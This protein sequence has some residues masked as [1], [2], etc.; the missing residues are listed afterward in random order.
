MTAGRVYMLCNALD[1]TVRI[2]RGISTDSPAATRK[3]VMMMQALRSAG[4]RPAILS[5]GRGRQD[6]SG[7]DH[8]AFAGRIGGIPVAYGRFVNRP[9]LSQLASLVAPLPILWSRRRRARATTL[10]LYNRMF[11][12]LPALWLAWALGY[13][14][15]L[16][17][18]DGEVPKGGRLSLRSR[19]LVAATD[20]FCRE[21]ALLACTALEAAT[22]LRPA[23]PYY[24]V[25]AISEQP[26]DFS[27]PVLHALLG[28]TVDTS[29]GA[30][31]L[32]EALRLLSREQPALAAQLHVHVTGAGA[33]IDAFREA[34]ATPQVTVHGRLTAREY[35]ALL[36][37]CGIGFALKPN[38]GGLADTT[39]PSKVTEFA[40]Q[41][42]LAVT[43]DISDVR[44]VLGDGA[45]YLTRNDPAVLA[46]LIATALRDRAEAARR[47]ALGQRNAALRCG[48]DE[49]AAFL[50]R[51][52][53]RGQ[54]A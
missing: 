1:D 3:I 21:G 14:V 37:R 54:A 28:G 11:S 15:M 25:V 46:S 29:T 33:M 19:I 44:A 53:T 6:G 17:L 24:G 52:L 40:G 47:A 32:L 13:R 48:A 43:T 42:M 8:P 50:A 22:R 16:D 27:A 41:G 12:H 9:L 38:G 39:F 31:L 5:L 35:Q 45:L 36:A 20:R 51:F 23:A 2:A 49:A 18:E 34:P 10:L 30:D 4:V 26:R 7:R